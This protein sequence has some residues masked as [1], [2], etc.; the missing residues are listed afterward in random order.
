MFNDLFLQNGLSFDRLRNFL[1][2]AEA[3]SIR[4]VSD[5]DPA[6]QSLIS[7]QIR[8]LE[9][10][11]G[12][13]LTRRKGRGLEITGA[14]KELARQIRLQFQALSDFKQVQNRAP[15]EVRIGS[16]NSVLEWMLIPAIADLGQS[17][18]S[19]RWSYQVLRTREVV[20][21]LLSHRMDFGLIRQ[22]AV[23]RPLKYLHLRRVGYALFLPGKWPLQE[24]ETFP[25]G[26]PWALTIGGEFRR[27]FESAALK[28]NVVLNP[29]HLCT[30]FT[31]AARLVDEGVAAA[32]LP[33]IASFREKAGRVDLPW[34]T[35][36]SRS[37]GLVWHPR[38]VEVRT[39]LDTV[40][41]ELRDVLADGG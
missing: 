13:E 23:V 30:S 7:R 35:G 16:G 10:F 27:H 19:F 21:A 36:C 24:P 29:T 4:A 32:V 12:T 31:Q 17:A 11:F 39:A 8:E 33:E 9:V 28:A 20:D 41:R 1:S 3:G 26:K 37:I 2:V 18:R 40:R 38:N 14:G 22:S 25:E 15:V 5:G 34:L 6:R